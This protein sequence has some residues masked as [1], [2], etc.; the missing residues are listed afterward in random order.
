[1]GEVKLPLMTLVGRKVVLALVFVCSS[2]VAL[3]TAT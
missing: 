3:G 1:M 2:A